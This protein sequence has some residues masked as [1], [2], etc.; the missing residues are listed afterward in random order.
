MQFLAEKGIKFKITFWK[1]S[2]FQ[3]LLKILKIER[4]T[5]PI[6]KHP[7]KN[8]HKNGRASSVLMTMVRCWPK[9]KDKN[10]IS[11]LLNS[12]TLLFPRTLY[13]TL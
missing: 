8:S 1:V 4:K 13:R 6:T 10:T 5:Y 7:A 12:G 2:F 3:N 11:Q 9:V